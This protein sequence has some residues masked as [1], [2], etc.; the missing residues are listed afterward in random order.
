MYVICCGASHAIVFGTLSTFTFLLYVINIA[1]TA[2]KY[3]NKVLAQHT[4]V[5][6]LR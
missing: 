3:S 6:N 2:I 1:I 4:I 5:I